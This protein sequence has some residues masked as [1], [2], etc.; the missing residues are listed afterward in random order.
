MEEYDFYASMGQMARNP[1]RTTPLSKQGGTAVSNGII[2]ASIC[3]YAQFHDRHDWWRGTLD[4]ELDSIRAAAFVHCSTRA[5]GRP[6]VLL[7]SF[8]YYS[9]VISSKLPICQPDRATLLF[10]FRSWQSHS[11]L[12]QGVCLLA[13]FSPLISQASGIDDNNTVRIRSVFLPLMLLTTTISI[14]YSII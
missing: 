5:C 10:E 8:G 12:I 1:Q 6:L 11:L 2:F 9:T 3:W 7:Y 4:R 13:A 14:I